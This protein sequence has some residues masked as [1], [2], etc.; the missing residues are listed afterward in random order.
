MTCDITDAHHTVWGL[1]K[2]KRLYSGEMWGEL[3]PLTGRWGTDQRGVM[4]HR[5]VVPEISDSG[6]CCPI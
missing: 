1:R 4:K 3:V 2:G 5:K 6:L